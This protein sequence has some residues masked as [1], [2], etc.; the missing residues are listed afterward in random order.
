[1]V[2]T[3]K[4]TYST[5]SEYFDGQLQ[6]S[7]RVGGR[8]LL[9][10]NVD[11]DKRSSFITDDGEDNSN[12]AAA[13]GMS[14]A[15]Y[16]NLQTPS[17]TIIKLTSDENRNSI[18]ESAVDLS[19]T[20]ICEVTSIEITERK[21][22]KKAS[23]IQNFRNLVRSTVVTLDSN[24]T[25]D[26]SATTVSVSRENLEHTVS[27][28]NGNKKDHRRRKGIGHALYRKKRHRRS[29]AIPNEG[30]PLW[31]PEVSTEREK[32]TECPIDFLC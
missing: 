22:K 8:N 7:G 1:M 6:M 23:A 25:P 5:E 17:G 29:R 21:T 3:E 15:E 28:S 24:S 30:A 9:G 18:I 19:P 27:L 10:L 32:C 31:K 12:E 4:Y 26:V 14:P 13:C 2:A 16:S 11:L 20:N